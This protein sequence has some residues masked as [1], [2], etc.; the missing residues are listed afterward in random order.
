FVDVAD[1]SMLCEPQPHLHITEDQA[2]YRRHAS[3][4]SLQYYGKS[5]LP[6]LRQRKQAFDI[7]FRQGAE[8]LRNDEKLRRFLAR[9]LGK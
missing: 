4:M 1:P 6:D 3:N 8:R 9:D 2:V 5:I 7:L